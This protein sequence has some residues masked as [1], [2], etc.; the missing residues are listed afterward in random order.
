[1]KQDI[2][3][4]TFVRAPIISKIGSVNNEATPAIGFAYLSG[5]LKKFGY[6]PVLIDAIG[7]GLNQVWPLKKYPGFQAQGLNFKEIINLIPKNSKVIGFS[8][9]FSSEWP[10]VR[11]LL[12]EVRKY[13][14]KALFVGGGEH[15]TGL[16]EY[17]LRDCSALDVCV[18]GEGEQ[19]F[20]ELIK[21]YEKKESFKGLG[22]ISYLDEEKVFHQEQ[23]PPPRIR[24]IDEIGWPFWPD[25]YLEKFWKSG[26]SYGV[27]T[28]KDMP[29][30]VSRGCPYQCT[31]C[32]SPDMW[33]TRYTLRDVNDVVDEAKFYIKRFGITSLQ[34]YDLTAITKKAWIVEFCKKLLKEGIK[35]NWSLPSGTRSEALDSE[36]L[37]LLRK[38]GCNYLV[39]APESA[40]SRT[41]K[42][43]KKK[44]KLEQLTK[45]V[46]EAK[47]QNLTVR[48]NLI[49]G[50]P[51]ETWSDIFKT[52]LY[53][54]KMSFHGVDEAPLFIFSPYP[55]TEI[56]KT[57]SHKNKI[58][59]NDAYFLG[60]SS[61]NSSYLSTKIINHN[62]KINTRIL[63]VVRTLFILANYSVSYLFF[64]K[65]ISRTLK[66]IFS[67]HEAVTVFEHRLKDLIRRKKVLRGEIN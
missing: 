29:F 35:L 10:L 39:Y 44:I 40:S 12:M 25:G 19:T 11:D 27:A 31:F 26:K 37:S 7:E 42:N 15:V 41:L 57:L 50:F 51:E 67:P 47:R 24:K 20:F 61:L 17:S 13:F 45:S 3:P 18:R 56:F 55:G 34:F 64:P 28:E 63:G 65:R 66:N 16:A 1:M 30:M 5:Y 2:L 21:A 23:S 32:S 46:L 62:P 6:E 8:L 38:T 14:P 48:I 33:T 49:I 58:I 43:I 59:L 54:L 52:L 9:M 22:G 53:G 4:I 60:L 36:S